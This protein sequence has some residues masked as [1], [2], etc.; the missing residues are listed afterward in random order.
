M[1]AYHFALNV[2]WSAYSAD[3]LAM[4]R[5]LA[6]KTHSR[7]RVMH[8]QARRVAERAT[9]MRALIVVSIAIGVIIYA[10]SSTPTEIQMRDA[11][12][13]YLVDQTAQTVQF[14]QETSGPSAVERVKAAGNNRF[15]I[16]AFRKLDCQQAR[17]KPGFD[18]T[19]KW[20]LI[21]PTE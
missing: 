14:T 20:T 6:Y 9:S 16:R 7:P 10:H 2:A 12:A 17:A 11:F 3:L 5:A 13:H 21:L 15:E 8:P 4:M 18:C 19:F 1:A